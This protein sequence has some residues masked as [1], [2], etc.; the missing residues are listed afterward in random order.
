[1]AGG[2]W[3]LANPPRWDATHADP[4]EAMTIC[5][6]GSYWYRISISVRRK[7]VGRIAV[8]H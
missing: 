2:Y 6:H 8:L 4:A 7:A 5:R 1:M 3:G